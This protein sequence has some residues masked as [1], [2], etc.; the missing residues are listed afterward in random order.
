MTRPFGNIRKLQS[1]RYQ[2]RYT[3]PDGRQHSGPHT[4]DT[5]TDARLWLS[6]QEVAIRR[7]QWT[8][9]KAGD[10]TLRSYVD[11]WWQEKTA[12]A[13]TTERLYQGFLDNHI[14]PVLG[15]KK[16]TRITRGDIRRWHANLTTKG[17]SPNSAAKVYRLLHQMLAYAVDDERI[18]SNPCAIKNAGREQVEER[19]IPSLADVNRVVAATDVRYRPMVQLAA[20][21][22]LRFGEL[23]GLQ[24]KHFNPLRKTLTVEQQ[25]DQTAKGEI[26]FRP[27]KTDAGK[28]TLTL[29]AAIV[30]S[31]NQHIETQSITDPEQLLFPAPKGGPLSRHNFR[32]R[33]WL[34]AIQAAGVRKM[35]FHDLRHVAATITASSGVD[36][37][38]L[39]YR[40]GHSTK[41][42]ALLYQHK[43]EEQDLQAARHVDKVIRETHDTVA[44]ASRTSS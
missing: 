14:L 24:R 12:L 20:F 11:L 10:I 38:T 39:M 17:L 15:D 2:A 33:F 35:R 30:E 34:P 26:R 7:G 37:K 4:F 42:A 6:E 43:T 5:K 16:L 44:A 28:R 9:P 25:L 36:L 22:G 21:V 27:P 13:P 19:H 40:I 18:S 23:A 31:L 3:G 29:P 32:K 1:G 41:D 8:D